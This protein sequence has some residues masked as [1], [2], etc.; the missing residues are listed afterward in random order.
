[1]D[2]GGASMSEPT[3]RRAISAT[4]TGCAT[5]RQP[6]ASA[7]A[8]SC[9]SPIS[10]CKQQRLAVQHVD[11]VAIRRGQAILNR[12]ERAAQVRDR[13]TQFMRDVADHLA[14]ELFR[15]RQPLRH[16]VEGAHRA[17]PVSSSPSTLTRTSSVSL[18]HAV[19]CR[20]QLRDRPRMRPPSTN[21][22]TSAIAAVRDR[23]CESRAAA[24]SIRIGGGP[25]SAGRT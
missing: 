9:R 16:V 4:S 6:P 17:A 1:M 7:S 8:R 2:T 15:L 24:A 11:A 22:R 19:G 25:A 3:A 20:R 10:R 18:A 14:L 21:A 5:E 13:R 23:H 12:L